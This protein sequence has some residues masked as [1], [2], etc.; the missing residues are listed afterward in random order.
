MVKKL[1]V[2]LLLSVAVAAVATAQERSVFAGG[3]FWCMEEA[4]EEVP[5]VLSVVSGY[6]QGTVSNPT[7]E[8]VTRGGTGHA[9]V[10]E[11]RY[12][13][14]VVSY[15]RLLEVFWR[16][17]DPFDGGGQFCDRGSSY[18]AGIYYDSEEERELAL[19][20]LERV[21]AQFDRDIATEVEALDTF[22]LAEQYHQ[23]YYRRNPIRYYYYK[24]A[25]GRERR[26]E[27]VW[28]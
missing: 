5:G 13:P 10:V 14:E 27:A 6:A 17:I 8:E 18:R 7:Y 9:E 12:D 16:N 23:D 20:S 28:G 3:C 2:L 11:V 19:E 15:E 26:L 1:T 21:R 24:T 25:C 22:Y 4:F